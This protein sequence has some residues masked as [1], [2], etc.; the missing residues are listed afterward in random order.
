MRDVCV[1]LVREKTRNLLV[2]PRRDKSLG[3]ELLYA[4]CFPGFFCF[5]A[6]EPYG[7]YKKM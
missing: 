3:D 2:V 1:G 4:V 5:F 6:N 7:L